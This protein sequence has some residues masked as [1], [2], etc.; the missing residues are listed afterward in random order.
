[1]LGGGGSNES[2]SGRN[3]KTHMV[4][5]GEGHKR[6]RGKPDICP[7]VLNGTLKRNFTAMRTFF[8][9]KCNAGNE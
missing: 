4:G 9:K 1:M 7:D 2:R 6:G 5:M 3:R 8:Q